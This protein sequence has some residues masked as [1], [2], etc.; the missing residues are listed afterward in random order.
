MEEMRAAL[1]AVLLAVV[2]AAAWRS[3]RGREGFSALLLSRSACPT[4][5]SSYDLRGEVCMPRVPEAGAWGLA[6]SPTV[7]ALDPR[8]CTAHVPYCDEMRQAAP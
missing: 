7:G 8:V 6:P 1:V 5:N 2:V 3:G 4:R